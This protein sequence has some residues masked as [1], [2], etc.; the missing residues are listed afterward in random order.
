MQFPAAIA[1]AGKAGQKLWLDSGKVSWGVYSI[2]KQAADAGPRGQKRDAAGS[3][4]S[5]A[6]MVLERSPIQESKAVKVRPANC[7]Y[8]GYLHLGG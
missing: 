2:A 4:K 6:N 1:E 8:Q 3:A 7:R 5:K